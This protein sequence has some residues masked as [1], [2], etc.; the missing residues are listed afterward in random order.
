MVTK[1][2]SPLSSGWNGRCGLEDLADGGRSL[3][4]KAVVDP[5]H[6]GKVEAHVAFGD[7]FGTVVGH[8]VFRPLIGFR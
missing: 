3:I 1:E 5:W 2:S 6:D 4:A 7:L 8:H